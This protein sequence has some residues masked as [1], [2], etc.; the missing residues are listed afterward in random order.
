MSKNSN[1]LIAFVIGAGVG[2]ALGVLFAPDSGSNTRDKL[3]F[4]LSKYKKELEELIDEL[5]EGKELHL[6]EAKTEGKRVITEAKNK[7]ENLLSD[8]N[9]LIDQINK[10]K[11]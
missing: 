10:D 6:N 3:S 1:S 4:R 5:V 7:A 8:V 11:N 9:K 2:A